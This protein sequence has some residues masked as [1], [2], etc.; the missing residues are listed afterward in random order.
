MTEIREE[1]AA[2]ARDNLDSC[3]ALATTGMAEPLL[4]P[5]TEVY[6]HDATLPFSQLQKSGAVGAPISTGGDGAG[7]GD[8]G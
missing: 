8:G 7:G 2:K 6:T 4:L 1:W 3:S 5:T